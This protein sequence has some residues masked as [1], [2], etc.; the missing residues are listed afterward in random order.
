MT[1]TAGLYFFAEDYIE[2]L[3]DLKA[4]CSREVVKIKL[5]QSRHKE[6]L[7]A[8]GQQHV[9]IGK[10]GDIE[11]IFLHYPTFEEAKEKWERRCSRINWDRLI[12]KNAEMN[13]CSPEI[14]KEFDKLPFNTKFIFTTRD[15][16]AQSQVIFK[17][18][19]NKEQVKDD[20]TLFN[21]YVNLTKLVKGLPFK[22]KQ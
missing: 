16:G 22:R 7:I 20:T 9:P 10:I 17:E 19:L 11:I 15:Y 1:P 18:Y 4:N 6:Q 3:K 12:V 14:V 2:F 21:K 8:K 5:E 13:G